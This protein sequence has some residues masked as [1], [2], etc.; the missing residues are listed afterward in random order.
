[1][2]RDPAAALELVETFTCR[3]EP[4]FARADG[5]MRRRSS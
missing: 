1:L 2:P 5:I 4:L 3:D